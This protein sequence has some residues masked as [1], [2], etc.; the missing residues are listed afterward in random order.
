[1]SS[2]L[3]KLKPLVSTARL[4]RATAFPDNRREEEA[5]RRKKFYDSAGWQRV[6]EA[7]L[8]RDPLCQACAVDS[9]AVEGAHVDHWIP[10][11][12]G[13][14]PLADDN[15]V[16]LCVP[17]HSQKTMA[18]RHKTAFPKIVASKSRTF[19]IG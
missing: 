1:M 9:L 19:S 2:R 18:E 4:S 12:E 17:H 7:K 16:T 8:R 11:A 3:S 5:Q 14:H 10:L 15:L 13:G 6:R